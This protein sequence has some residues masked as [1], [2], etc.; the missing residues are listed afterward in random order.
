MLATN[1]EGVM[2][3]TL[4]EVLNGNMG[5]NIILERPW[6]HDMKVMSSIY[7]QL[8][9]FPTLERTK[10][11]RGDQPVAREMNAISVSSSKGK[12]HAT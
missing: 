9:K 1:A 3:T 12:E 10:Q 5:Y 8:L 7:H 2:K 11:I 4:F 6:L